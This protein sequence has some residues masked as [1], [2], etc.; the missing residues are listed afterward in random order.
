MLPTQNLPGHADAIVAAAI[1]AVDPAAAVR[2]H[3]S[4]QKGQL[5]LS[6]G[7]E[8]AASEETSAFPIPEHVVVVAFGKAST[9]MAAAVIECI[10]SDKQS[11]TAP[12]ITGC[13]IDKDG[14]VPS[15]AETAILSQHPNVTLHTA[16]HPIPDTRNILASKQLLHVIDS[17]PPA[18]LVIACIS[19]GGSALLC[20]PLVS[21]SDLQ[22][23]HTL[24]VES[25]LSIHDMNRIRRRLETTK[26]GGLRDSVDLALILSDVTGDPLEII[27]SG[28]TVGHLPAEGLIES[29]VLDRLQSSASMQGLPP[30]VTQL[31]SQPTPAVDTQTCV[32]CLVGNTAAAV[33]AA[34]IEAERLGYQPVILSTDWEGEASTVGRMLA[35]MAVQQQTSSSPYRMCQQ[36]PVAL[37]A[38]GETTVTLPSDHGLGGRNQEVALSAALRL[39]GSEGIVVASVGTDGTD[40]PTDAAGGI[41]DGSTIGND[42]DVKVAR[43][44]LGYHDAYH[45]LAKARR[46][47]G[48]PALK[49]VRIEYGRVASNSFL[50]LPFSVDW[51]YRYERCRCNGCFDCQ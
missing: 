22:T 17:A 36:L 42:V 46:S 35:S 16:A 48:Q 38:G 49:K 15:A 18:A 26:G 40:G 13:V 39:Q 25:G 11:S 32:N 1:A 43:T 27:A 20:T 47:D 37:I 51:T 21:L 28:P 44:A 45:F 33:H 5:Q 10:T 14:A 34:S 29:R 19:G 2:R 30:A 6:Q 23:T 12:T 9:A 24:L 8:R 3:L 31:L 41:V 7:H 4:C 50:G